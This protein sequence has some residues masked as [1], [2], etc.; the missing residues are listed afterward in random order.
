MSRRLGLLVT[1][2]SPLI[3]L[4][5]ADALDCLTMPGLRVVIP[6]MVYLEVTEN[7]AKTGAEEV[8]AW[9][10]RHQAQIEIAPTVIFA[11]FQVLRSASPRARSRGRGEQ[12]ALEVLN[13]AISDDPELEA[14][15]L[16]EDNDIRTRRFVRGLPERVAALSTGDLL[17]ELQ[18]AGRIQSADHLLDVAAESERN[19]SQQREPSPDDAARRLLRQHLQRQSPARSR[20]PPLPGEQ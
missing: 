16:Y 13:A 18:E 9:Y 1:D 11:E 12:A 15:L 8:I 14:L 4:A 2:A 17:H 6:D 7:L 19:V 20:T 3:T 10:R 5:A